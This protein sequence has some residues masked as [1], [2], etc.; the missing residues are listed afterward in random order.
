MSFAWTGTAQTTAN[1]ASYITLFIA[2]N[3]TLRIILFGFSKTTSF[4]ILC[5][6][7]VKIFLCTYGR[8]RLSWEQIHVNDSLTK[9]YHLYRHR[10]SGGS[11]FHL[12]IQTDLASVSWSETEQLTRCSL[13]IVILIHSIW[14]DQPKCCLCVFW[15][16]C[17]FNVKSCCDLCTFVLYF[18]W[19]V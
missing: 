7:L 4:I 17:Q 9:L 5:Y 15:N 16:N 13:L 8:H 11:T 19:F 14:S 6:S 10:T 3:K 12:K 1:N 18:W 2:T